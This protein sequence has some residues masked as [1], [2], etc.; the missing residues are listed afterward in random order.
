MSCS[1]QH[2]PPEQGNYSLTMCKAACVGRKAPCAWISYSGRDGGICHLLASRCS[3]PHVRPDLC[4]SDP[5]GWWTSYERLDLSFAFREQAMAGEAWL[6]TT[7]LAR[8]KPNASNSDP[9]GDSIAAGAA[10]ADVM[11]ADFPP[12]GGAAILLAGA[13]RQF[14]LS[15]FHMSLK[16]NL[17]DA[18]GSPT[19][20]FA[21]LS[22]A[23]VS[24]RDVCQRG[25][26]FVKPTWQVPI[27]IEKDAVKGAP[28]KAIPPTWHNPQCKDA[29]RHQ[30]LMSFLAAYWK[31][32]LAWVAMEHYEAALG[33]KF[34]WVFAVRPDM[35][36]PRAAPPQCFFNA[37]AGKMY[38]DRADFV[39]AVP[40]QAAGD[41]IDAWTVYHR[42]DEHSAIHGS[43]V[44][45]E[46]WLVIHAKQ[47]GYDLHCSGNDDCAN[48][49]VLSHNLF[50][51]YWGRTGG[52]CEWFFPRRSPDS[53]PM[54]QWCDHF[55]PAGRKSVPTGG[56]D[57][58]T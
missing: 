9:A 42:C 19:R 3:T 17:V 22:A 12:S 2:E 10:V 8:V 20:V 58:R 14:S 16:V 46:Q 45:P 55:F 50:L 13:C 57:F 24:D 30:D 34:A 32:H 41:I 31:R 37:N 6:E 27:W 43:R 25:L 5:D 56:I 18:L 23:S 48:E 21:V 29:L 28:L 33:H 7:S 1:A 51:G 54:R 49:F 26:D 15:P 38:Q 39:L 36:Y 11:C 47:A 4:A 52:V 53:G 40:R 35:V 44:T